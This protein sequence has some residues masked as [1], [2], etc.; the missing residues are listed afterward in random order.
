MPKDPTQPIRQQASQYAGVD[1]GAACT[2]SSFKV[3]KKSFL[4]IGEQGGRYKAMFKLDESIGEA[5]RLAKSNPEDFHVGKT[6]WVTARFS[7]EK[8]ISR[9][10]WSKWLDESYRL[11]VGPAKVLN[12]KPAKKESAQSKPVAKN[13]KRKPRKSK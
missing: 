10:L 3:G 13:T 7:D 5:M 2:Q 8:P 6:A 11:S 9:K 12:K 1:E 4:F